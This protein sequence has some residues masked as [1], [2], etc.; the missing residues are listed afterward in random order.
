[1]Q[2]KITILIADRNLHVREF[3]KREMTAAGYRILLT[4]KGRDIVKWIYH[5]DP[6]DLLILDPD[7]P[8]LDESAVLT[9]LQNRI[10][11]MPVVVHT[12]VS[13][14][15]AHRNLLPMAAFV[16][17]NGSSVEH[18]KQVVSDILRETGLHPNVAKKADIR[19]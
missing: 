16:E 4:A 9:K 13:V 2:K 7:L 3:L 12:F 17:K 19:K 11:V 14:F 8:D 15:E 18:L 6:V 5:R 10:P 1:V